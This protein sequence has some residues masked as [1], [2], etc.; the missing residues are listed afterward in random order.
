MTKNIVT[1]L[2]EFDSHDCKNGY[3]HGCTV[4]SAAFF[5]KSRD[6][7]QRL[8][9]KWSQVRQRTARRNQPDAMTIAAIMSPDEE[10]AYATNK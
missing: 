3:N 5:S 6:K 1:T 4:C 8:Q 9:D 2:A 10:E 7:F